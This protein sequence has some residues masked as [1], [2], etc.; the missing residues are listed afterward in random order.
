MM[1]TN[2][3]I[4]ELINKRNELDAT[5]V[6]L[7]KKVQLYMEILD[8]CADHNSEEYLY[9][10]KMYANYHMRLTRAENRKADIEDKLTSEINLQAF[11][12]DS[13]VDMGDAYFERKLN[14]DGCIIGISI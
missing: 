7:A 10:C 6:E 4:E 1:L 13:R 5:I 14:R 11:G 3:M 12:Y 2:K 9:A 8:S